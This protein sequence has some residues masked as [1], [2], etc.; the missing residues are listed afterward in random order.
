MHM[1]PL[2]SVAEADVFMYETEGKAAGARRSQAWEAKGASICFGGSPSDDGVLME[3]L[4]RDWN[5]K[6]R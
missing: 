4:S 2:Q 3:E 1:P 6:A 5:S